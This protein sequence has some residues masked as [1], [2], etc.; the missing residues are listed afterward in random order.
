MKSVNP[1]KVSVTV[2]RQRLLSDIVPLIEEAGLLEAKPFDE[3]NV[4]YGEVARRKDIRSIAQ[5][6]GVEAVQRQVLLEE[7]P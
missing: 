5:V 6:A 2:E 4:V 7:A 1:I 3:F